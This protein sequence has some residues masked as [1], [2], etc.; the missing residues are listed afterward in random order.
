MKNIR[1][2][3]FLQHET[4]CPTHSKRDCQL[5]KYERFFHNNR[6]A[7]VRKNVGFKDAGRIFKTKQ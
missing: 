2:V 4:D 5:P 1:I 3:V 7:A 6:S